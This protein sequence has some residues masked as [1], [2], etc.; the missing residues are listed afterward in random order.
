MAY[1]VCKKPIVNH[2][3]RKEHYLDHKR[4]N[5]NI[6]LDALQFIDTRKINLSVYN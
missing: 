3:W 4:Y 6:H 5:L 2:E 1:D